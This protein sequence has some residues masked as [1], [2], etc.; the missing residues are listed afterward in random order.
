MDAK[1]SRS[2]TEQP[3]YAGSLGRTTARTALYNCPCGYRYALE[4]F[5]SIDVDER[6][7]LVQQL[8]DGNL[9][10]GTCP[11]CGRHATVDSRCVLHVPTRRRLVLYLPESQRHAELEARGSLL[12]ELSRD[13]GEGLPDYVVGFD[14]A[15]GPRN[16]R[17][18]LSARSDAGSEREA[19][20][21]V[22]EVQE[23]ARQLEER[24][25]TLASR[26][27][28]LGE[29]DTELRSRAD[30]LEEKMAEVDRRMREIAELER[31]LEAQSCE[32]ERRRG[33]VEE[34]A[35]QL[36]RR[37]APDEPRPEAPRDA[38]ARQ[39]EPP[40]PERIEGAVAPSAAAGE[41]HAVAD[42]DVVEEAEIIDEQP[43]AED[44][45]PTKP[46]SPEPAA[47][48]RT[49]GRGRRS[50]RRPPAAR[51]LSEEVREALSS[52]E[53]RFMRLETDRVELFAVTTD[54][55]MLRD[56]KSTSVR[57]RVHQ[58]DD[59]SGYP[60]IVLSAAVRPRGA[61]AHLF[62]W[63]LDYRVRVHR[64]ILGR[65]GERCRATITLTS[66]ELDREASFAA[67]NR[68]EG[69]IKSIAADLERFF[70]ENP[71]VA[72]PAPVDEQG[73]M[74]RLLEELKK[75]LPFHGRYVEHHDTH[76]GIV[77][78][79]E[80][81][82]EWSSPENVRRL[83]RIYSFPLEG[84]ATIKRRI[85]ARAV[86]AGLDLPG[87]LPED[88]ISMGLADD[89]PALVSHSLGAFLATC[90]SDTDL[91]DEAIAR[92]WRRLV[93]AALRHEVPL[94]PEVVEMAVEHLDAEEAARIPGA[95]QVVQLDATAPAELPDEVLVRWLHRPSRRAAAARE[96]L[97]RGAPEGVDAVAD[98]ASGMDASD[99]LE[100]VP[101]LLEMDDVG[102]SFFFD[103]L[104]SDAPFLRVA[105][106]VGLGRLK[107]RTA[108]VPLINAMC[109]HEE[110][111]WKVEALVL[112]R[113]GKAAIR[114]V[115]QFLRN[116]RGCDDR[117]VFA[118]GALS[119]GG[120]E[121]QVSKLTSDSDLG[122]ASLARKG[123]EKRHGIQVEI[124]SLTRGETDDPLL[125]F[126]RELDDRLGAS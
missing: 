9:N 13:P 3:V 36:E 61:K 99:L 117:L 120:C 31:E 82:H 34:F 32:L 8:L 73:V 68:I 96:L 37:G 63:I 79:L 62:R 65:L 49:G 38:F 17:G 58:V 85:L 42:E 102:E 123:W 21:L 12:A 29:L 16:L 104:K 51:G 18:V 69:N 97:A 116:P 54:K 111:E 6:A 95:D 109:E 15:F 30:G 41:V 126:L 5:S 20:G 39:V 35:A 46:P 93:D 28:R 125:A 78:A 105:A 84:I 43:V 24:E 91:D 77:R 81:L 115:E 103:A 87:S 92:N 25:R 22:G 44:R 107:L 26:E 52:P 60:W 119:V 23:R 112:S 57:F 14:V 110:P 48:R 80:D 100:I 50:G 74:Q 4:V 10:Q 2:P 67:A 94:A 19:S 90:Q 64:R 124:E 56:P 33:H 122:V 98:V 70:L 118:V 66:P 76:A 86:S 88:A 106:A 72:S 53:R 47:R 83:V 101:V 55:A 89:V 108:L 114:T 75:P 121:E 1:S 45:I 40:A 7:D 113:Y 59:E 27:Q 11:Y 71:D